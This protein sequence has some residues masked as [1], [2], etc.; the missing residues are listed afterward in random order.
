MKELKS[1]STFERRTAR[2]LTQYLRENPSSYARNISEIMGILGLHYDAIAI[3]NYHKVHAFLS[4]QRKL[5]ITI[6][7]KFIKT[8]EYETYLQDG[9]TEDEIFQRYMD[10]LLSWEV[11]PLHSDIDDGW[12]YKLLD[13]N[14]WMEMVDSRIRRIGSEFEEK[15][16]TLR[17]AHYMLP[18]SAG[19]ELESL[20][21]TSDGIRKNLLTEGE[22]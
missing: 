16:K 5:M 1:K 21:N 3:K 19:I 13:L 18:N 17:T 9:L 14:S 12:K 7:D 15:I 6:M 8:G 2:A 10:F 4:K 11:I 20:T 22:D